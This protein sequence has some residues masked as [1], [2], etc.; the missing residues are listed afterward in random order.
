MIDDVVA[1]AEGRPVQLDPAVLPRVERSRAA[2][3][4]FVANGVTI[5]NYFSPEGKKINGI[6]AE[7]IS[8]AQEEVLILAFS[9]TDELIGTAVMERAEAGVEVWAVFEKTIAPGPNFLP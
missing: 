3:E 9:F 2:V 6:V 5:E 1:V 8:Q 7:W 4:Q